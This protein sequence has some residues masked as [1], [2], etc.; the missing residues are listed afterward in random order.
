MKLVRYGKTG[1]EKPGLMH[2]DS[3]RDLSAHVDDIQTFSLIVDQPIDWTAF[4]IWLTMLLH[5][6]GEH[7][8]RVKGI[9]NVE[10]QS[11]PVI[12]HGVQHVFHPP[13]CLPSSR[14]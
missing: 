14:G 11:S 8:L 1:A 13:D 9:L 10:G 5:R 7:V 4:G 6:H 3:L 12:I 2:G